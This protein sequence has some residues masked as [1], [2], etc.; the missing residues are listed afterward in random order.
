[1]GLDEVRD[2]KFR[3]GAKGTGKYRNHPWL[4]PS[5][6]IMP[7]RGGC[8]NVMGHPAREIPMTKSQIPMK[9]Q[10]SNPN[11]GAATARSRLPYAASRAYSGGMVVDPY[12][13]TARMILPSILSAN[14][15]RLGAEIT[16]VLDGGGDFLHLDIMDGH[17]VPNISFGPHVT[18]AT[19]KSTPCYLDAHLMISDPLKYAPALIKAGA[20][21]I[22]FHV[23]AV[24]DSVATA[25]ELRKFGCHVGITLRPAT[26]VESIYPALDYVDMVL[27]MSVVPG[28]SGQKFMPEV[29]PKAQ[30]VKKRLR[31]NQR[32]E[33][34]GGIKPDNIQQAVSAGVDWFVVASAIFD[35]PNRAAAIAQLRGH[36][37]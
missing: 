29:L 28:F 14:F 1:M 10:Y 34:D 33:I 5:P 21:G 18:E 16:E 26:L 25:K 6:G 37:G 36:L 31:P 22:T 15:A 9:S 4:R 3:K 20:N 12:T 8:V 23:E 27:I 2:R 30:A 32:L 35:Q 19:R 24:T 7:L 13:S 11:D 17:F